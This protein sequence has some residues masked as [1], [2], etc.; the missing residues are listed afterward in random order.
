M[1]AALA[2]PTVFERGDRLYIVSPVS[3]FDP[4]EAEID[5]LAF[6]GDLRKQ[7]PNQAIKWLRGQFVEADTPNKNGQTLTAGDLQIKSLEP[8]FMPVTVMHNKA[9]AVGLIA[10]T[11][12]L[13]PEKDSVP[14]A[15]IDN[16]LAIWAHRFPETAEEID[17]NY[18][19]GTL[20]QSME[21]VSPFYDCFECGKTFHKL[22]DGAERANWC[23]H[24]V[25]GAGYGARILRNVV[26]TGTGLIFGTR[27]KEGANP[28]AHLDVFQDEVAEHHERVHKDAGR[29]PKQEK[30][31]KDKRR[32]TS[33]AE[34]EINVEE[35]AELKGRPTKDELAAAEKRAT[36]AEEAA[37]TAR[38]TAE[39]AETAKKKAED[40]L[41]EKTE[42]LKKLEEEQAETKLRD[43]RFE[44]L[45]DGF[46][47]ALGEVTKGNLREDAGKM[48]DEGWDK[49]LKELEELSG[50]KR[51]T[52]LGKKGSGKSTDKPPAGE[53]GGGEQA[54][55]E[56]GDEEFDI[57]ELAESLA[58]EGE[59]STGLATGGE[60]SS[61]ARGLVSG[62][63]KD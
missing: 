61:I 27:G 58:G 45:G 41:A 24:L 4:S 33:M 53:N 44:G 57:D 19:Q 13:V 3:P 34:T 15:R 46:I 56:S 36:E 11:R 1:P 40:E 55:H 14:N 12:L 2:E 63:K 62:P 50:K 10:D 21:A 48:D 20:M 7:A 32:K 5:E 35:Y 49:R 47:A 23:E 42:A 18:A 8:M 39:E 25:E 59:T 51:D 28:K 26:F 9:T 52:A 60:R 16:S 38:K 17:A 54:S 43:E 22:P 30:R 6:A 37:A 31:Q 29:K